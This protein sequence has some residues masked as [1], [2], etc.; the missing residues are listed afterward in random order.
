MKAVTVHST[1]VFA[2]GF[3][4]LFCFTYFSLMCMG[5]LHSCMSYITDVYEAQKRA[6]DTL[7]LELTDACELPFGCWEPNHDLL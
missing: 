6:L 2:F 3:N 7:E 1:V 5:V 4:Y